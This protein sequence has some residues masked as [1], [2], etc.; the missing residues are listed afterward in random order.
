[1]IDYQEVLNTIKQKADEYYASGKNTEWVEALTDYDKLQE[2]I[3]QGNQGEC[4]VDVTKYGF[5]NSSTEVIDERFRTD[6]PEE[7]TDI[8]IS[9]SS[10]NLQYEVE[11]EQPKDTV[12]I[13]RLIS[14]GL[15]A[16]GRNDFENAISL[17][18]Q[19][20]DLD[21]ENPDAIQAHEKAT[22]LKREKARKDLGNHILYAPYFIPCSCLD[23]PIGLPKVATS[24]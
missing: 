15:Q 19:A 13:Q 18:E 17:L 2:W 11:P 16:L 5:G 22:K 24:A 7:I 21:P 6:T 12:Q 10:V 20:I 3:D 23:D 14:Q 8:P 4:P 9:A 1:M